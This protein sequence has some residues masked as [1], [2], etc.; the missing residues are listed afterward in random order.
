MVSVDN[1]EIVTQ[2]KTDFSHQLLGL[3]GMVSET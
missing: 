3:E 2:K 1:M